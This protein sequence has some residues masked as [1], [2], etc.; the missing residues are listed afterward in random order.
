MSR[1]ANRADSMTLLRE[2]IERPLDPG[3]AA[4]ARRRAEGTAPRMPWWRRLIV[5]VISAVLALG[6]IWAARELRTPTAGAS[7][8][9]TLLLSEI[10]EGLERGDRLR[11]ANAGLVDSI[12]QIQ[13][14]SL[15]GVDAEYLEYIRLLGYN[16]GGARVAGHGLVVMLD[17]S[18]DAQAGE[19]DSDLGRVQDLDLQVVTNGLWAAGAEAVAIN[20][21]RL[22]TVSAIRSAG[23]AI[24]VDLAPLT[25]PY[26]IEAVGDPESMRAQ[27]TRSTAGVHLGTL[28]DA[29]GI[30]VE[31]T[32]SEE[33]LLPGSSARTLRHAEPLVRGGPGEQS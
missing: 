16:A 13:E 29:F 5:V 27:L 14:A 17:D 32:E 28:R 25:R 9:R 3:Y 33:L 2:V 22:S 19:P 1:D 7:E 26:V 20:G 6:T 30:S 31:L 8:A 23:P 4:A 24:F 12:E 10:E 21:H 18:R 15:G 11:T